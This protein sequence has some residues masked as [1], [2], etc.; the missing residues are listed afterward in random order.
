MDKKFAAIRKGLNQVDWNGTLNSDNCDTNF[1]TCCNI[2]ENKLDEVEPVKT[3]RISGKRRFQEPWLTTGLET[4]SRT[5]KKLYQPTLVKNSTDDAHL[6]YKNYRNAYNRLKRKAKID[7]YNVKCKEYSTNTRL[8]WKLINQT[9]GK[10]KHSGS[11]IPYITIDCL[12]TYQPKRIAQHFRKFYSTMGADLAAT[13]P[14]GL[15]DINDCLQKILR[16]LSSVV[17][18]CTNVIEIEN[19]ISDMPNKSSYGHDRI[20]N[21]MLKNCPIASPTLYKSYSINPS[22]K[23]HFQRK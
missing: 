11:I 22:A 2:L 18:M 19:L 13:I 21:I 1:N 4:T 8:L 15:K 20:S 3:I 9:T 14:K 6:H 5:C 17:L 10:T 16:T 7:Y 23:A 12:Q